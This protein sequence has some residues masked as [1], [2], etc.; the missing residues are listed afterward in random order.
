MFGIDVV[1]ESVFSLVLDKVEA[2]LVPRSAESFVR[3]LPKPHGVELFLKLQETRNRSAAEKFVTERLYVASPA[4]GQ[5]DALLSMCYQRD[6]EGEPSGLVLT[7]TDVEAINRDQLTGVWLRSVMDRVLKREIGH[8]NREADSCESVRRQDGVPSAEPKPM[9]MLMVDIDFFKLV[10]DR[11]GHP[12]GD[13]VIRTVARLIQKNVRDNDIVV[14]YGGEEF[15]V[16]MVN[17]GDEVACN[18]AERVRK[19]IETATVRYRAL[20]RDHELKM[21]VSVGV[22]AYVHGDDA[23]TLLTRVDQALYAAKNNG[24]NQTAYVKGERVSEFDR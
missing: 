23:M 17:V 7:I 11:H 24:R 22:S 21:T 12:V 20:G 9:A 15:A 2:P 4:R 19:A 8:R 3:P 13:L 16:I 1:G 6:S 18:A 14:R 5:F 10:N